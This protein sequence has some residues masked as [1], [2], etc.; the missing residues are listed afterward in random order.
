MEINNSIMEIHKYTIIMDLYNSI[1]DLRNSIMDK[2]SN[3]NC[4]KIQ[5][6]NRCPVYLAWWGQ[7]QATLNL[8]KLNYP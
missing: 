6:G 4:I 7:P 3:H 5:I 1:M 2:W 8:H